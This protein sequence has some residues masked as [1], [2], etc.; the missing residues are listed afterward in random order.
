MASNSINSATDLVTS[1]QAVS[2]G[3]LT[4]AKAKTEKAAP[5]VERAKR[6]LVALQRLQSVEQLETLLTDSALRDALFSAAGYSNKAI[7][8]LRRNVPEDELLDA[9]REVFRTSF[10]EFGDNFRE[11]IVYRYLLTMGDTLGGSMRNFTGAEAGAKLSGAIVAA[12]P[13]DDT[14]IVIQRDKAS[15]KIQRIR[16]DARLLLF[17]VK[18]RFINKNVDLILLD[19]S[20]GRPDNE[21]LETPECYVACGELKGGIDP[22]G[23]DEHWKTANKAFDRIRDVFQERD[24]TCPQL[25]FVGAA[26]VPGMAREIYKDLQSDR[27]SYAANLTVQQQVDEVAEWLVTLQPHTD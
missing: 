22:A 25:F 24:V 2:A 19:I 15:N 1:H 23:A 7:G 3:F 5:Y 6:L 11:E 12:L 16:W 14:E 10:A 18:P 20:S 26:I 9:L 21:L 8:N 17:D 13:I 4:Q 27:L